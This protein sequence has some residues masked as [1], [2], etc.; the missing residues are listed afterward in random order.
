MAIKSFAQVIT[1]TRT[2]INISDTD[3]T[4]GCSVWL[5]AEFHGSSAKVAI[6]GA[7]VTIANGFHIYDSE[8]IGP[9]DLG[10]GETIHAI[11]DDPAGLDLRVLVRGA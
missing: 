5:Y 8:K 10:H 6:G 7:D 11:S 4:E 9:I 3:R 1:T 2:T